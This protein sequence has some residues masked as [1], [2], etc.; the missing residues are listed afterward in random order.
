MPCD[1]DFIKEEEAES[2]AEN[3]KKDIDAHKG[4]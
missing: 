2:F 4:K 3:L 1:H